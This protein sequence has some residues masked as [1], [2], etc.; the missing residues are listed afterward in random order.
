MLVATF[1]LVLGSVGFATPQYFSQ[2]ASA[3]TPFDINVTATSFNTNKSLKYYGANVGFTLSGTDVDNVK[4]VKVE[5]F[6]ESDNLLVTN[7][8]K[9]DYEFAAPA[10]SSAFRVK[11]GEYTTSGSQYLGMWLATP[12]AGVSPAK[13]VITVTDINGETY[14]AENSSFQATG[15]V[16][17]PTWASLFDGAPTFVGPQPTISG[18]PKVDSTLTADAGSWTPDGV[19]LHY[20]WKADGSNIGTDSTTYAI[21][22][23]D[24]GKTI[25][26]T[27]TVTKDGYTATSTSAAFFVNAPSVSTTSTVTISPTDS[28]STGTAVTVTGTVSPSNAVGSIEI[29]DGETS[30]GEGT[31]A[32]GVFTVETFALGVGSHSFTAT[33]TPDNPENYLVSTSTSAAFFV[34][35][36]SVSTT[37]TVTISPTGSASTG[38]AV[39][40]TGTVSPSNAV[41]SIEILD[42]ETSLGEGTVA[43]GV[44][45]VETFALGVGSHSFTAT[46][47]PD[48]PENY[49]VSTSATVTFSVNEKELPAEPPAAN[50]D[51]LQ[52]IIKTLDLNVSATTD[53]F[54]SSGATEGNALD[55]LDVSK[56]FSGTLPWSDT[57]DS[58]VDVY[59]Y[60]TPVFLGTFPVINGTVQITGVNLSELAAGGHQL[61]FIGQT[62]DTVSVM[63]ITVAAVEA[64]AVVP[65]SSSDRLPVT[66]SAPAVLPIGAASILLLLGSGLL[67]AGAR[68]RRA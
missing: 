22:E 43:G 21:T 2:S 14:T 30:L 61:V 52:E 16:S 65:A 50:T 19:E 34:N 12:T 27:V 63:A 24:A 1:A 57:S 48:N 7:N 45:T 33:F 20:Q 31:V 10:Y 38:T 4:S 44:F 67:I 15:T 29:L 60:S 40:V 66:G 39:T 41:G 11:I 51:R 8:F 6:D 9:P 58:F 17:L 68:R 25:T 35:A 62:S 13:A 32:G 23:A 64:A 26:V 37:S 46:F 59:A 49:L 36:P 28:A 56:P 18:T 54:V 3:A 42:G 55:S 5:L 53:S 47:T